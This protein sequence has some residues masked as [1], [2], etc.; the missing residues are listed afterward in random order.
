MKLIFKDTLIAHEAFT[1]CPFT[2]ENGNTGYV[3]Y[4][5]ETFVSRNYEHS[6]NEL[7]SKV[8]LSGDASYVGSLTVSGSHFVYWLD[9]DAGITFITKISQKV[10]YQKGQMD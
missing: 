8:A 3:L 1:L 2:D 7:F 4:D 6:E 5:G 9:F 10:N